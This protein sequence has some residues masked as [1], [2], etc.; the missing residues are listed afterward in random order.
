MTHPAP[1]EHEKCCQST[2]AG[3]PFKVLSHDE[4]NHS[5]E[6]S[7]HHHHVNTE[8]TT[9]T[10]LL[11]T[12]VLNLII[13]IIQV[14]AGVF[15]HSMALISD[16]THNF[17]DFMAIFISYIAY[18]IGRKGATAENT[19]GYRRAEVMAVLL[20]VIILTGAEKTWIPGESCC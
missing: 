15:A 5:D 17:S 3:G 4:S 12:L 6:C 16:A 8:E 19:F 18:R 2:D 7:D 20:N 9:G 10:R 14:I 1:S 13:P 11:I